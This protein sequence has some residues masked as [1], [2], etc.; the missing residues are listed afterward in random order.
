MLNSHFFTPT[1]AISM[2][3]SSTVLWPL[4]RTWKVFTPR[5][6]TRTWIWKTSRSRTRTRTRTWLFQKIVDTDMTR[7]NPGHACPPISGDQVEFRVF[8]FSELSEWRLNLDSSNRRASKIIWN[9]TNPE[10]TFCELHVK[11]LLLSSCVVLRCGPN[12]IGW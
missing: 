9:D 6:R 8:C 7:T 10:P 4:T 2:Q 5:T 11:N 3:I 1:S 12:S